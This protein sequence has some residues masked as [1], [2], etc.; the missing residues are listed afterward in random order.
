MEFNTLKTRLFLRT[1][2]L[3][4]LRTLA[5]FFRSLGP[6]RL[7]PCFPG[8]IRPFISDAGPEVIS[9]WPAKLLSF[10]WKVSTKSYRKK[11]NS[12]RR[13]SWGIFLGNDIYLRLPGNYHKFPCGCVWKTLFIVVVNFISMCGKIKR[14]LWKK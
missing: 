6:I 12:S 2:T 1:C 11:P 7:G 9:W 14:Y 4:L 10:T 5:D 13:W 3:G 8:K